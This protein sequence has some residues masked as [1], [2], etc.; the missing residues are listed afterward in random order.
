MSASIWTPGTIETPALPA[1]APVS[2]VPGTVT[3]PG[4]NFVGDTDTGFWSNAVG[5]IKVAIDGDNVAHFRTSGIDLP[6][7]KKLG[8]APEADVASAATCDIGAATTNLIRITGTTGI[9]SFGTTYRGPMIVRFEGALILTNSATLIIPGGANLTTAA[10]DCAIITPKATAG[11]AD[12]WQIVT[13]QRAVGVGSFTTLTTSGSVGIGGA[14]SGT[15]RLDVQRN[16][17]A[18]VARFYQAG[19]GLSTA[20]FWNNVG[21]VGNAYISRLSTGEFVHF[22]SSTDPIDFY[23]NS[24]FRGRINAAGNMGVGADAPAGNRFYVISSSVATGAAEY[25]GQFILTAGASTGTFAQVGL[26]GTSIGST[27]YVGTNV[28]TGVRGTGTVG[29]AGLTIALLAGVT[30]NITTSANSTVT[31]VTAFRG[32]INNAGASVFGT[33]T[34]YLAED[35]AITATTVAGFYGLISAGTNKY[36]MVMA[37]TAPNWFS[38][39]VLVFGAGGLGYTTGSGGTVTQITSRVT[40]VTLNKTNGSITLVSAA[41]SAAWQSFTVTNSTVAATDTV[42]L[43]QRSGTDL[44]LLAVTNVAAGSFRISFATTGGTTVEQ[45]VFNFAVIKAVNA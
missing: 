9:T 31:T 44:H 36:N 24:I 28:I 4:I 29:V 12:G 7:G 1:V 21:I 13:Y 45:P 42:I 30:G 35:L 19:A 32:N 33:A 43:S 15:F 20:V 3:N 34:A 27:G 41:G 40:G 25:G 22:T 6:V 37:G 10:G 5:N 26:Q 39:D 18:S 11:V 2:F 8:F 14:V 17:S 16:D 38:G 23:T